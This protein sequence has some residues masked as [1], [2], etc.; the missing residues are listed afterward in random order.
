MWNLPYRWEF[1]EITIEA[2][3]IED[4]PRC[5]LENSLFQSNEVSR[6]SFLWHLGNLWLWGDGR[7]MCL[8]LHII[9]IGVSILLNKVCN[10]FSINREPSTIKH[11]RVLPSCDLPSLNTCQILGL[12][13]SPPYPS[14][15]HTLSIVYLYFICKFSN[16]WF[17]CFVS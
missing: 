11:H 10:Y 1:L 3:L 8:M 14:L 13:T 7:G 6:S 4:E 2:T 17:A 5:L 16:E 12:F 15:S 9:C